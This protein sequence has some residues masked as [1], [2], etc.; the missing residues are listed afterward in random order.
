MTHRLA[1]L[2]EARGLAIVLVILMHADNI[3][4]RLGLETL[5]ALDPIWSGLALVRMPLLLLLSGFL[6]SKSLRKSAKEF[7][8][9]KWA[10]IL[11]PYIVWV[12]IRHIPE[13]GTIPVWD[14]EVW[15]AAGYLWYLF[16]LFI[17]YLIALIA[18]RLRISNLTI[19]LTLWALSW[20]NLF[21]SEFAF[22]GV[23]FFLGA[24]IWKRWPGARLPQSVA[25]YVSVGLVAALSLFAN[26]I[27][28]PQ[29]HLGAT[30]IFA[31]APIFLLLMILQ[32]CS[33]ANVLAPFSFVGQNSIVYY[34][35][36]FPMVSVGARLLERYSPGWSEWYWIPLAVLAL[37]ACTGIALVRRI[38]PFKWL[39]EAPR[40]S[41]S[42]GRAHSPQ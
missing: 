40:F 22:Y 37:T 1:W 17:Y 6:L 30:V 32:R 31:V 8:Y 2:D 29:M 16:Y 33:G 18:S 42:R 28:G 4:E 25:Y 12:G 38:V 15:F 11:W 13:F 39:F 9:G 14:P 20:F 35:A 19:A 24:T 27:W 26:G 41:I 34:A 21:F 23:F 3:S 10:L 7:L 36:H 5:P